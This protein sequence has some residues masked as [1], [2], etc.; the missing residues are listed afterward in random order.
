MPPKK[1]ASGAGKKPKKA[2]NGYKM[3]EHLPVGTV[4]NDLHKKAWYLGKSVGVGGFGEIYL[5]GEGKLPDDNA[6]YVVKIEPSENGPLFVEMHFYMNVGRPEHVKEWSA[7]NK[8]MTVRMPLLRGNGSY[9]HKNDTYRFLV[10]DR[11]GQDLDKT[12]QNGKHPFSESTAYTLALQTLDTLQ[13]IHSRNYTHNDVKAANM[14]LGLGKDKDNVFLVDFGLCVKYVKGDEH[15]EYKPDPRKAHD[16][17]IEYCSRDA[18]IG[19]TGR[20]SDLEV[21]GYNLVHWTTGT[22]PWLKILDNCN[23]VHEAKK[24]FMEGLPATVAGA[25]KP[26]QEFLRYVQGIEF[27]SEPDY[28]KCRNMFT[29]A[30]KKSGLPASGKIDLSAPKNGNS[31]SSKNFVNSE[32]DSDGSE[33][34]FEPSPAKKPKKAQA[35]AKRKAAK[36]KPVVEVS[37]DEGASSD[38]TFN[39][40]PPR[41]NSNRRLEKQNETFKTCLETPPNRSSPRTKTNGATNGKAASINGNSAVTN[42]K[43]TP[44]FKSMGC[45]TSPGFVNRSE[46]AKA[47][48]KADLARAAGKAALAKAGENV[49]P[50]TSKVKKNGAAE[51]NGDVGMDSDDSN[52]SLGN[53]TPAMREILAKRK[54]KE[55]EKEAKKRKKPRN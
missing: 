1:A 51:K 8:N 32:I 14:L 42:G 15:K 12:F 24:T 54:A 17:T 22:L 26:V 39:P 3:P 44:K 35:P 19:V 34:M 41:Q 11:Y 2:A 7:R 21:L 18:H 53:L 25:P 36:K 13:Y 37:E 30:L 38:E 55:E 9:A 4:V 33:D 29:A 31:K 10:I 49:K 45:Q 48:G 52:D 5:A 16:G 20:R 23:K 40:T 27:T 46:A 47:A 28:D 50:S 43:S 6:K